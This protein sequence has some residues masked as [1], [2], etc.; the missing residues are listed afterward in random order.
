VNIGNV[1]GMLVFLIGIKR[2]FIVRVSR[3]GTSSVSPNV[4]RA[5]DSSGLRLED[6]RMKFGAW[7]LGFFETPLLQ[8]PDS[9]WCA[10]D[11]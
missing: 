8:T 7:N 2:R 9:H 6:S 11:A 5:E 1:L 3:D 10:T 4:D